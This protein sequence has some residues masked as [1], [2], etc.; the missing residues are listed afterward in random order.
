MPFN[1]KVDNVGVGAK[2]FQAH[3][4]FSL[5]R[6]NDAHL[7]NTHGCQKLIKQPFF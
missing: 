3:A 2:E 7:D 5:T 1:F 6:T 4:L